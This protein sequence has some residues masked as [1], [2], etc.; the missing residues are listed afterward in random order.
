MIDYRVMYD[1]TKAETS[2]MRVVRGTRLVCPG[3]TC[4]LALTGQTTIRLDTHTKHMIDYRVMDNTV[5][6]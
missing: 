1:R 2:H 4:L 3:L 6:E 5:A